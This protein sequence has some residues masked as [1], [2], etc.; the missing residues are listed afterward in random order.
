MTESDAALLKAFLYPIDIADFRKQFW[1]DEV[2]VI[3][4]PLQRLPPP[5]TNPELSDVRQLFPRYAGRVLFSKGTRSP[6]AILMQ[7]VDPLQLYNMGLSL[8]L[9]DVEPIVSGASAFLRELEKDLGLEEGC[10]RITAWASPSADG[11]ACHL[12][13]EEVFSIQLQGVKRFYVA[14]KKA[15]TSPVGMQFGPGIPPHPDLFLQVSDGFPEPEKFE[16]TEIEMKPGSVL[17]MPRG[18][19]HRT[20][21]DQDSLSVSVILS[22]ESAADRL[23]RELRSLLLQDQA[24]R[25]PLYDALS[26]DG[27]SHGALDLVR[28]LLARL[29]DLV[30]TI[31]ADDLVPPKES[32]RLENIQAHLRFQKRPHVRL[33][34]DTNRD[35][36]RLQ[37]IA[38]TVA[39][40]PSDNSGL[41]VPSRYLPIL[42]W[43]EDRHTA[44]SVQDLMNHFKTVSLRDHQNVLSY[45]TRSG[46]L[47]LLWF[48]PLDHRT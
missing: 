10:A 41:D 42:E 15:I 20:E 14:E 40:P 45:L 47:Q 8:Y 6:R 9:P 35:T 31:S 21:A 37:V 1:P 27:R 26:A 18:V 23:L 36:P 24:W 19:W 12:D 29:P 32:V 33:L 17:F 34:L 28:D 3:H 25:R 16:F 4:G 38:T 46:F 13:A 5:F 30:K 44:F 22:P 2:F 39:N 48:R 43:L 11:I 7:N